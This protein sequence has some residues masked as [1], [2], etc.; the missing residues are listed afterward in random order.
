MNFAVLFDMDGVLVDTNPYHKL[1]IQQFCTKHGFALSEEEL[2][3]KVYG[4]T[5]TDWITNLFGT[6]TPNELAGY[7]DE[8]EALF[9][10]I[11]KPHVTAVKGLIE[12]LEALAFNNI[13][14]AIATS[15]PR[16]NV[17]F[18]LEHIPIEKYFNA[19]LD[20]RMV[21]KGK[22]NPE[23]YIKTAQALNLPNSRCIVIEDSISGVTAG[24][25]SGSKVIGVTTT[26]SREE[27]NATD[28]CIADF[29]E[30]N[31]DIV[32]GIMK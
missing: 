9:R 7:A 25:D 21:T 1:A 2:H 5:N 27:L 32:K 23:I 11:Y 18:I 17:D 8:K 14:C 6:L 20:E 3:Q 13:P 28:Y 26:H 22:P 15:A 29:S 30:L 31:L 10:E 24:I 19:I 12:F 16:A 4:R